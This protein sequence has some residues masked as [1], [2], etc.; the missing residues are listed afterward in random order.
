MAK[1]NAKGRNQEGL[2]LDNGQKYR[3][4]IAYG[5]YA[6]TSA[7]I[8]NLRDVGIEISNL[9]DDDGNGLGA[10][11]SDMRDMVLLMADAAGLNPYDE[12]VMDRLNDIVEE[13]AA[14]T[15]GSVDGMPAP[16]V[17]PDDVYAKIAMLKKGNKA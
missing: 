8:E 15:N 7:M 16:G 13:A 12:D 3:F 9:E 5:M 2:E 11:N 17:V 6:R 10:L 1:N 14:W 4:E